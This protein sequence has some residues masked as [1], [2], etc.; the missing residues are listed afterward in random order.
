MNVAIFASAFHPHVGGVEELCRQLAH[1]YRR[2]GCGAVVFTE[3]WPRTLPEYE[4]YEGIPVHRVP[5]RVPSEGIKAKL[6]YL[7]TFRTIRRHLLS[8]LKRHKVDVVHVQCVSANAFYALALQK[9]TRLPL[10]LTM[11]G[12]LTM[13]AQRLFERSRWAR[14]VLRR[15][16]Q[17][18]NAITACSRQTLEEAVSFFGKP[19]GERG[20]VIYNGIAQGEGV[21]TKPFEHVRPYVLAIGRHVSQKGFDVL[22]QAMKAL[23]ARGQSHDLVLAGHGT[24]HE[25]LKSLAGELG[26]EQSVF[27]PGRVDHA[28]AM[29][30][31]AGCSVFVLPSR[32]EPFGIVNLE[33]M[34]VGKPIVATRVGGVPEIVVDERNG[35][36]VPPENP[37]ALADAL[38][39][40]LRDE[41]L[42]ARLGENGRAMAQ[43]FTWPRIA[44]EYMKIYE[45]IIGTSATE[46]TKS[47]D[48]SG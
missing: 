46:D 21:G 44:D 22:L 40:L 29:R 32:H 17:R 31:F 3:R 27:F 5:F 38:G 1:E 25:A 9:V 47:A 16:L 35:L 12:E 43:G 2:R 11:Q 30:L 42:R 41:A 23:A 28:M 15:G 7:A 36:L 10:V 19:L 14:N 48:Q 33:A 34:V 45:A 18:A 24:E 26:L 39:K 6:K 4:E 13:D 37:E 8:L 20:K